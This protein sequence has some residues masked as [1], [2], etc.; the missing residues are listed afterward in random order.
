MIE[1]LKKAEKEK[2]GG[3]R[4]SELKMDLK[5]GWGVEQIE[6]GDICCIGGVTVRMRGNE[7][8]D[9]VEG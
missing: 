6:G 2:G 3:N 1:R 7:S 5:A 9:C 4:W 8:S